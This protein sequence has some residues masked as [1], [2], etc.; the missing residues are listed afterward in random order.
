[1]GSF[2]GQP[3]IPFFITYKVK[4]HEFW[5]RKLVIIHFLSQ[6]DC[7][8]R[9]LLTESQSDEIFVSFHLYKRLFLSCLLVA[10]PKKKMKKIMSSYQACSGS[11]F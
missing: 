1:M 3:C 9:M 4:S 8:Y 11:H 10:P 7:N 6:F 5:H 2:P